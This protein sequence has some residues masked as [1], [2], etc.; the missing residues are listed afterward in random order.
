MVAARRSRLYRFSACAVLAG[1][2]V[3]LGAPLA[4]ASDTEV[5]KETLV[6]FPVQNPQ[7]VDAAVVDE[8]NTGL[9]EGVI[10]SN[11]YSVMDWSK[12]SPPIQRAITELRL[13]EDDLQEPF[14]FD[15]ATKLGSELGCDLVM[16]GSIE[17]FKYDEAGKKVEL[18]LLVQ[19]V[20]PTKAHLVRATRVAG[21]G[22]DP[23]KKGYDEA[24]MALSAADDAVAQAV[25]GL[26]PRPG[27]GPEAQPV[28]KKK[29]KN[30]WLYVLLV[31]GL[32]AALSDTGGGGGTG[33][34]GEGP[35]PP[36]L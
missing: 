20:E 17:E 19:I 28:V 30:T 16:V 5:A 7:N 15:K 21:V 36:P 34:G 2:T 31:G 35:P 13:T 33:D 6:I 14:D 22:A 25:S 24:Q 3:W 1:L 4:Y 10:H 29:S 8:V 9:R 26:K 12:T 32:I 11:A 23:L 27:E 18:G